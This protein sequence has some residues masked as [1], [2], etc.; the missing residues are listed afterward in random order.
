MTLTSARDPA[1]AESFACALISAGQDD[2]LSAREPS[3]HPP[4]LNPPLS[5]PF[6]LLS[7]KAEATPLP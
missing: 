6:C 5:L 4:P 3:P 1:S 2:S 7:V